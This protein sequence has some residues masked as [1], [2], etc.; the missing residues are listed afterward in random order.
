[1]L[2]WKK[3]PFKTLLKTFQHLYD[4][5]KKDLQHFKKKAIDPGAYSGSIESDV[6]CLYLLDMHAHLEFLSKLILNNL[7][8]S[9]IDVTSFGEGTDLYTD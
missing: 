2:T 7:F 1:L 5:C 8:E 4:E 9:L 6:L 3:K